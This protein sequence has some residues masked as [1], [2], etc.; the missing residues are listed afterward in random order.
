MFTLEIDNDSNYV[1]V[2]LVY[3]S[4]KME[5]SYE[6]ESD[7]PIVDGPSGSFSTGNIDGQVAMTWDGNKVTH[8]AAIYD[9]G[10]GGSLVQRL[11]LND[12]ELES[13][14]YCLRKWQALQQ[15]VAAG[16]SHRDFVF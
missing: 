5:F 3:K 4:E 1:D 11:I 15:H 9:S 8:Y 7:G 16:N 10:L 6:P 12:A 2:T 13:F 14:H